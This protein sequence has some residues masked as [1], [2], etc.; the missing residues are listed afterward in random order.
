MKLLKKVTDRPKDL[1][2][3]KGNM[4]NWKSII[5]FVKASN[6]MPKRM[7]LRPQQS[8]RWISHTYAAENAIYT[9]ATHWTAAQNLVF[10]L[11]FCFQ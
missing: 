5:S 8:K 11:K 4:Q 1:E 3:K 6:S 10:W 9:N 2:E 7:A